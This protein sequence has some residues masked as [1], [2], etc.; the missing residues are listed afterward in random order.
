MEARVR[1]PLAEI[2][3]LETLVSRFPPDAVLAMQNS[4]GRYVGRT[5]IARYLASAAAG[6]L[7]RVALVATRA[8]GEPAIAIYR[9]DAENR[10]FRAYGIFV[11]IQDGVPADVFG[12]ADPSLFP[13]F[14]LPSTIE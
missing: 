9:Y 14:E 6:G 3:E 8:N 7:D 1:A 10:V 11:L 12:F 4:S 5:A 13:F 2:V